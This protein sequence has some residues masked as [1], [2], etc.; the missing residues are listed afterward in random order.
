MN[1]KSFLL[2]WCLC[3]TLS[4]PTFAGL[5]PPQFPC[6]DATCI[7]LFVG[8][9]N[10]GPSQDGKDPTTPNQFAARLKDR[11][12]FVTTTLDEAV[13]LKLQKR[14]TNE[15]ITNLTFVKNVSCPIVQ[16]GLYVLTL[17]FDS[18]ELSGTFDV[19]LSQDEAADIVLKMFENDNV[20]IFVSNAIYE[21]G[22]TVHM[23]YEQL[24]NQYIVAENRCWVAFVD[25]IP[26]ANWAHGCQ[27]LLIDS[28][29]GKVVTYNRESPPLNHD[30]DFFKQYKAFNW[31]AD[32]QVFAPCTLH[33]DKFL[34][35]G[36][37]IIRKQDAHY[38]VL[39]L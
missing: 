14:T 4:L 18:T 34:L 19:E 25:L 8:G 3:V 6:D 24:Y 33:N 36:Q 29:S 7:S 27:Y 22:D 35:N 28:K 26:N 17:Q 23:T 21:Q 37:V 5:I 1:K 32:S 30:P 31:T 13:S 11:T 16:Y 2:L 9:P 20:E 15:D 10:D 39:G 38:N 12:L